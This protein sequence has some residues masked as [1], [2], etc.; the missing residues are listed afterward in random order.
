[1]NVGI[2]ERPDGGVSV[3]N[4]AEGFTVQDNFDRMGET[5]FEID[6]S[7]LPDSRTFRNAWTTDGSSVEVDMAKAKE[8]A[9]IANEKSTGKALLLLQPLLEMAIDEGATIGEQVIRDDRRA[10]RLALQN[11]IDEINIATT[12]EQ[13]ESLMP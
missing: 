13:L 1:M 10:K 12:A 7:E 6:K 3:V 5:G 8:I 9:I 2:I 4:P 11:K